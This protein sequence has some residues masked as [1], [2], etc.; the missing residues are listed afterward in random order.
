MIAVLTADLVESTSYDEEL[1]EKVLTTL[2]KEFEVLDRLYPAEQPEFKIF[3]GDSFQGIIS[4]PKNA[5]RTVL[6]IRTAV[7]QIHFK[8]KDRNNPYPRLADFRT[9]IGIGTLEYEGA[10][11][12]ESNG[13]AFRF[14]GL[15]LDEMKSESQKTRIKTADEEVNNEFNTS[16]F[17]MDMLLE[18]WTTASA[19]VVYFLLQG[20]KEREIAEKLNISQS[21]VNQRKK[22]SGWEAILGLLHRYEYVTSHKFIHG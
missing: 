19:E 8:K 11:V 5:L 2:K 20:M 13:Q 12:S 14:S 16:F 18:K 7:N 4:Q 9:A 17:L 3:R 21:A 15:T 6:Q 1:L 22:A 10:T